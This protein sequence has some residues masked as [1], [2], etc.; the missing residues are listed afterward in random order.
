M[1]KTFGSPATDG[2]LITPSAAVMP[3][4]PHFILLSAA[5]DVT[6]KFELN[7]APLTLPLAAGWHPLSPAIISAV[8][9]GSVWGFVTGA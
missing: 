9:A 4:R 2:F 8:S 3:V 6:M 1:I 5:A 7:G